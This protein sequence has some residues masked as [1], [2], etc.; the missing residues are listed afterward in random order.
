MGR[1]FGMMLCSQSMAEVIVVFIGAFVLHVAQSKPN[2]ALTPGLRN[3]SFDVVMLISATL[4]MI[5][6]VW[7]VYVDESGNGTK[8]PSRFKSHVPFTP[9]MG[10]TRGVYLPG[11]LRRV[12][13][14]SSMAAMLDCEDD[15]DNAA[16]CATPDLEV[17]I[18]TRINKTS[19]IWVPNPNERGS[20]LSTPSKGTEGDTKSQV[21]LHINTDEY[22][23]ASSATK[24]TPSKA[25]RARVMSSS[26]EEVTFGGSLGS[27]RGGL[28]ARSGS[29]DSSISSTSSAGGRI[30]MCYSP[31]YQTQMM[32]GQEGK[33]DSSRIGGGGGDG[34]AAKR[35]ILMTR[36]RVRHSKVATGPETFRKSAIV[37]ERTPL[38]SASHSLKASGSNVKSEFSSSRDNDIPTGNIP[39]HIQLAYHG[40]WYGDDGEDEKS[41]PSTCLLVPGSLPSQTQLDKIKASASSLKAGNS[42]I[43]LPVKGVKFSGDVDSF[44]ERRIGEGQHPRIPPK[45]RR[46]K[47][48]EDFPM[49][50]YT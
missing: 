6:S 9:L 1:A 27:A 18:N 19:G 5:S 40:A 23:L 30:A 26:F 7:L 15:G 24:V 16:G 31:N 47:S 36:G 48:A 44:P 22:S 49:R 21:K 46:A 43:S 45:K 50:Y 34:A 38:L 25:N 10:R 17:E 32:S 29:A 14:T 13:H 11:A 4:A 20:S 41:S 2:S 28:S 37:S 42:A 3:S 39:R 8:A 35:G 33:I 12:I